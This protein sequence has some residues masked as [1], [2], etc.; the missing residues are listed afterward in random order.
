[1]P[2]P[3]LTG[4]YYPHSHV[5]DERVLKTAL[6]LWDNLEWIV[7]R[8]NY[9]PD[10]EPPPRDV[11]EALGIIGKQHVVSEEAK[12]L[13]HAQIM[14]LANERLPEWLLF[15]VNDR[16]SSYVAYEDKFL[17]K[18]FTELREA[19]L[20]QRVGKVRG[21]AFD[22]WAMSKSLGLTMMAILADICAGTQRRTI[23]NRGDAYA[24]YTRATTFMNGGDY[25]FDES[26]PDEVPDDAD[27]V[28]RLTTIAARIVSAD[29][30]TLDD[31]IDL[32]IRE[33]KESSHDLRQL[34]HR[35][36]ASIDEYVAELEEAREDEHDEIVRKFETAMQIDLANLNGE[37]KGAGR[38]ALTKEVLIGVAAVGAAALVPFVGPAPFLDFA[39]AAAPPLIG[40]GMLPALAK[41]SLDYRDK[42]VEIMR[43]HA[44]SWLDVAAP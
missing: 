34:R 32:R 39:A 11:A 36:V 33:A 21:G 37:L 5:Y 27:S 40:V 41:T 14:R 12:R 2:L 7:P 43:K 15:D 29:D 1:M 3:A 19:G 31:L 20:A 9:A 24:A 13:A 10:E 23:T 17:Y 25:R 35:F 4:L 26:R 42:R 28:I 8:T 16:K 22:D 44:M 18:T 30:L 38:L 6:L